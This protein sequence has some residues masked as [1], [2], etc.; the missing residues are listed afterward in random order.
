MPGV[1][2]RSNRGQLPCRTMHAPSGS[3]DQS[4]AFPFSRI[5]RL[6]SQLVLSYNFMSK[7]STTTYE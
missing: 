2:G 3:I 7:D 1:V 6:K 4:P 5:L